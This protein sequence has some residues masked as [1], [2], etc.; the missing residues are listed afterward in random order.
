MKINILSLI[1]LLAII[2][3]I[4][5]QTIP[6]KDTSLSPEIRTEDVLSRMTLEEKVTQLSGLGKGQG[7]FGNSNVGIF[8]TPGNER[9]GIPKLVMG[10][11]ITG[12][13]SGRDTTVN[14]T[15][16]MT[17]IGIAASW[18]TELYERAA[19]AV[20]KEMV[21]LNQNLNLGTTLNI[22]RHPLGGRNWESFSEDPYLT[23]RFG[24]TY[25][26]AMQANGIICGPKHFVANNQERHRFDINNVVDE[27]TLREIYLP[28]FKAAVMEGGALNIMGAYNRLNGTYM[29]ENKWLLTDILRKEWGFKGF[30]LSDFANGVQS[31]VPSALAGLNVE[32]HGTKYYGDKLIA[33][34]KNGE[35]DESVVDQLLREK[36]WVMFSMGVFDKKWKQPKSIVHSDA[37]KKIALDVARKAAVLLKNDDAIL[38]LNQSKIKKLAVIGPNAKRTSDHPT[39]YY[40]QG[41]GSGRT[42]HFKNAINN[43]VDEIKS[44]AK[45]T[46]VIY[47]LGC[48]VSNKSRETGDKKKLEDQQKIKADKEQDKKLIYDAVQLAKHVDAVVL[49]VGLHG[50]LETEGWDREHPYLPGSQVELIKQV[51][52]VNPNTVVVL[53]GGS[54]IDVSEWIDDVKG[55]LYHF[56]CGEK[57]GQA[58]AEILFGD[59]NPSGKLPVSFPKSIE[60]YPEGSIL[61][62]PIGYS[63]SNISN[64]Y[65]EGIFVGYRYFDKAQEDMRFP[66]GYGLSYTTF[67]YSQLEVKKINNTFKVTVTITNLGHIDGDEVVQLYVNDQ[68]SSIERPVREL[69][70]FA[71][72]SLKAGESK[73]VA[74]TLKEDAFAFWSPNTKQWTVESGEFIIEVGANSRD[75]KL[76]K[77]IKI[78]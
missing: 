9:L 34:I 67:D 8:G 45:N 71:R 20:A 55:V 17:P 39:Y 76:S 74:F 14:S 43:P 21:A 60:Q 30:V 35:L 37:H 33:A 51:S 70:G 49:V 53:T 42:Y 52:K 13:R 54:F 56:Y 19:T 31:T 63:K 50:G 24:V 46:K 32:M 15:Y 61:I 48:T 27:R 29:C 75:I 41:G 68:K 10:H 58:M 2:P 11:G 23:S 77:T 4:K 5:A 59:V 26:K 78:D 7:E 47:A 25:V 64:I 73:K 62:H 18:D 28:G 6:Y 66:F 40:M 38:P 69:K 22:I 1:F 36:L 12:V 44:I 65:S 16:M 57:I 72:V 3:L